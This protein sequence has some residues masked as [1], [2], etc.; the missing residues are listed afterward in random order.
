MPRLAARISK[1]TATINFTTTCQL[2]Q[3]NKLP[4][5][6]TAWLALSSPTGTLRYLP[7]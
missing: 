3:A 6:V 1:A 7:G 2:G 4:S 5:N